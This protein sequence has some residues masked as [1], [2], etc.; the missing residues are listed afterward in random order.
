MTAGGG[1]RGKGVR[2]SAS[3]RRAKRLGKST[4]GAVYVEF[5]IAFLPF[6]ITF[7]CLWQ[8]A[9]LYWTKLMVDHAAF[10]AARAAAV[11]VGEDPKNVSDSSDSVNKLTSTRQGLVENAAYVAL[12]PLVINGTI[13]NITVEYPDPTKPGGA[14]SMGNKT[15]SPMSGN[16]V[17]NIRVRVI[18]KMQC[19]IAFANLIM[20]AG[21]MNKLQNSIGLDPTVDVAGESIFPY[22]GAAYTYQ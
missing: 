15:Y 7:L 6:L 22:Q 1:V 8:V 16:S 20:C 5:I 3:T 18:A 17:G 10:S 21:F 2:E 13:D 9:I 14:D 4:L 11:I 19:R 12:A